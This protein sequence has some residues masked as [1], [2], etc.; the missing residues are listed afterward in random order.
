M[1]RSSPLVS[2]VHIL[3]LFHLF[4]YLCAYACILWASVSLARAF[5]VE[6]PLKELASQLCLVFKLIEMVTDE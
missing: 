3:E 1:V 4:A 5:I 2:K 6:N